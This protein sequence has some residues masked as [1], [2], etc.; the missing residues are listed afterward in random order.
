MHRRVRRYAA[1]VI[2]PMTLTAV[3]LIAAGPVQASAAPVGGHALTARG[4]TKTMAGQA[5]V[6]KRAAAKAALPGDVRRVCAAPKRGFAACMA[7]V[8][9]NVPAHKGLFTH[10]TTPSGYGPADLQSAYS[11]PSATAGAGQTVAIVDAYDNPNAAADLATYRAQYGLPACTTASGCFE[12]VNQQGQ[13]GSYPPPNTDWAL[14][15]SLDVDMVSAVCPACHIILVEANSAAGSDLYAAEDEAVAL[16]A[17]YVSNSWATGEYSSE[18]QDDQYFNH[19][20]VVITAAGGD[21]GYLGR[22]GL[23]NYP[24]TS[25][26]VTAVGGTTLT[27]DSSV[28]RGWAETVWGSAAGGEGTGSG[29]SLYE[30]KPAWQH[31]S[32]C[33][34]RTTNDVSAVA[35]PNTGVAL[36]DSGAGGWVV[37]GGTSVATPIIASTY[38][39]AGTPAAGTYPSSYP[40]ADPSALNDV[41]SGANGTC[42]PA[43]LCTA[44]PGYD[45]PTGLG[46]PDGTAAFTPAFYGTVAGTITDAS[47]SQP[48]TGATVTVSGFTV[49]TN[50]SGQYS[51]TVP[52]GSY[53]VTAS[54]YGYASQSATGVQV[55]QGQTVTE[56]FALT[57]APS[58]TLSGTVTD[59]SGHGWPLPVKITVTGTPLAPLYTDAFTGTYSLSLPSQASYTLHVTAMY[60][61][62]AAR[63]VTVQ[64]G[65]AD[66]VDN[67]QLRTA[68]SGC[69]AP[70]YAY[71]GAGTQFTGWT[72]PAPR[73]GW[74][75]T[76]NNGSGQTWAFGDFTDEGQ[77]PGGDSNFAIADSN[78]FDKAPMD[79]SLVSPTVDLSSVTSPQIAFDTW[80]R[81][82]RSSQAASVDLSVDGGQTWTTVWKRTVRTADGPIRIRIPQA[83]GKP[84]VQV[85]F[86]YTGSNDWWWSVDN[87]FIGTTKCTVVPGGLVAGGVTAASTGKALGGA[88]VSSNAN[89]GVQGTSVAAPADPVLPAGFY[90]LF[91]AGTGAQQFTATAGGYTPDT[92]AVNVAANAVTRQDWALKAGHI[93]VAGGSVSAIETLGQSTTVN[94][95]FSNDGTGPAPLTLAEA[96]PGFIPAGGQGAARTPGVPLQRIKV[97]GPLTLAGLGT[98]AR[99]SAVKAPR[100]RPATSAPAGSAWDF[101]PDYPIPVYGNAVAS[102]PTTGKVYSA[103]GLAN[104]FSTA[105]PTPISASYVYDPSARQWNPIASLPQPLV[106]S[107][108]A[109]LGGKLYVAGGG[110]TMGPMPQGTNPSVAVY[111]YDPAA[112]TW[113]DAA[114]LPAADSGAAGA[115]LGGD[116][117]LVGGCSSPGPRCAPALMRAVYRYDPGTNTWAQLASYPVGMRYGSCA[118]IAGEIVCTGGVKVQGGVRVGIYKSTYVYSPVKNTWSRAASLPYSGFWMGSAGANGRLQVFGGFANAN[119][120]ETN[121]ASEYDPV[122][123]SWTVL[124][125][126]NL[127]TVFGGSGCGLYQIGGFTSFFEAVQI[128]ETLPGYGQCGPVQV[129]WLRIQPAGTAFT[130]APGHSVTVRIRLDSS[131]V[132]QPGTY[133]AALMVDAGTPDRV[134]PVTIT[135][136]VKPPTTWGE[137]TGTVTDAATGNP[138][139]GAAVNISGGRNGKASYTVITDS[140]GHYQWW[141]D[142]ADDPLLVSAAKDGYQPQAQTVSITPSAA[143]TL[144]FALNANPNPAGVK[145]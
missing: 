12:K 113:S 35:N 106:D 36:Y 56:S 118:G 85:R 78:Y 32:G 95:T 90:W 88:T 141:L 96:S 109:S 143:T 129:P 138:V 144:N 92:A 99:T 100:A 16:G 26:Y 69:A 53:T 105:T 120:S 116:L 122:S 59:G 55:T 47:T 42:T 19:P 115:V 37:V 121:Q 79:T 33:A 83:A 17:K 45:G 63:N 136:T 49:K 60:P 103:G 62:Y 11:L 135:L 81:P 58:V 76:D 31:D 28:P 64:L 14:E 114:S 142:A 94:V 40:Y 82:L 48:I 6:A 127:P 139:P 145:R 75:V 133:T 30:A 20:G 89:T 52:A 25:Q 22:G 112:G 137:L 34:N 43:Y 130:V 128:S 61:G 80:Y 51:I 4:T 54:D 119:L 101:I 39:L 125:N 140:T 18:T 8:R 73:D 66:T 84:D 72:W 108:A 91:T 126:M 44:G 67:I 111:V 124:P 46:T 5:A 107:V 74:K 29:C 23:D 21:S 13:Q 38:A 102:D 93:T 2:A 97:K 131:K 98:M 10:D 7:L 134:K 110:G 1:L 57:P 123:N 132:T 68:S 71:T 9:T 65:T 27:R 3:V 104:N 77:P 50:S 86:H 15:E 41:T 24:A 117:Y 87:V 70:G